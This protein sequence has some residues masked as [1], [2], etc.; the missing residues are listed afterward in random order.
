MKLILLYSS[1]SWDGFRVS[2]KPQQQL[3]MPLQLRQ[4]LLLL[5]LLLLSARAG[6]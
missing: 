4:F 2:C 6:H 1:C 5:L 3:I